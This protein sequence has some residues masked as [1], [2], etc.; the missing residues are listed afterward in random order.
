MRELI[1][2]NQLKLHYPLNKTLNELRVRTLLEQVD[3]ERPSNKE[4]VD[5]HNLLLTTP[6]CTADT[7]FHG[8]VIA[9]L[10]FAMERSEEDDVVGVDQ[11][12]V[13]KVSRTSAR[14]S[15]GFDLHPRCCLAGRI[16]HEHF[17]LPRTF[18]RLE[19]FHDFGGI[20]A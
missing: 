12:A 4:V 17:R 5:I 19:L 13:A 8:C 9:S 11:I 6:E 20:G 10:S 15:E 18:V 1:I 2:R 14:L 7:L 16:Q 3:V